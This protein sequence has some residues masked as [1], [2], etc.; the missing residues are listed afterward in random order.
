MGSDEAGAASA[1]RGLG[2]E[3]CGASRGYD[4]CGLPSRAPPMARMAALRQAEAGWSRCECPGVL[5]PHRTA[6]E[7]IPSAATGRCETRNFAT[8]VIDLGI[9]SS[10]RRTACLHAIAARQ[11]YL[12]S[13]HSSLPG[14]A[15]LPD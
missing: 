1:L 4:S 5:G 15:R 2:S 8:I 10:Q 3:P 12:P 9:A 11:H 13:H 7:P 14:V 6:R